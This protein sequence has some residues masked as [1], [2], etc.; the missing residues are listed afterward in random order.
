L[1]TAREKKVFNKLS[2]RET[3]KQRERERERE[4]ERRGEGERCRIYKGYVLEIEIGDWDL[5]V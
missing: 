1:C 2:K 4:R 3:E 5:I